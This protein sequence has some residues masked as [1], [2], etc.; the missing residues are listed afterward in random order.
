MPT[1]QMNSAELRRAKELQRQGVS[2]EGELLGNCQTAS[3]GLQVE[4]YPTSTHTLL[5]D[6]TSELMSIGTG[7]VIGLG[8]WNG[9]GRTLRL[10]AAQLILTWCDQVCWLK[11]PFQE[12]PRRFN[13]QESP[14]RFNYSFSKDDSYYPRD[15]VLNHRFEG[16]NELLPRGEMTGFLL[17]VAENPIPAKYVDRQCVEGRLSIFYG[18]DTPYLLDVK[19]MV[20]RD[21]ELHRRQKI[22]EGDVNFLRPVKQRRNITGH[23]QEEHTVTKEELTHT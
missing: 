7:V 9:A 15:S 1:K 8:I 13:Y 16:K 23:V 4:Q 3:C 22:A 14:R 12:S 21:A 17:G 6:V 20:R 19:F 11:D 18:S 2:L 10:R 5:F